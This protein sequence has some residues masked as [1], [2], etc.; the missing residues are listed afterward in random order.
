MLN[1]NITD[2]M[3]LGKISWLSLYILLSKDQLLYLLFDIACKN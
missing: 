1:K 2:S 3:D